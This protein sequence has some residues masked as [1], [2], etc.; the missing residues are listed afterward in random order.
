[1][2]AALLLFASLL[3]ASVR[4]EPFVVNLPQTQRIHRMS[5]QYVGYDGET[6][7][8]NIVET[9]YLHLDEARLKQIGADIQ[10]EFGVGVNS[11]YTCLE[12]GCH[13][14]MTWNE[15]EKSCFGDF[16]PVRSK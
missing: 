3:A 10:S 11:T 1:M 14:S 4:A 12:A 8:I 5:L 6:P 13:G 2:F 9:R 7:I 16:E 15:D